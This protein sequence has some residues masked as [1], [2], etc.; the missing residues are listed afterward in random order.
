M[1]HKIFNFIRN[2]IKIPFLIRFIFAFFLIIFSSI[3][4]ILPIFPWS[5]FVWVIIL[6]VGLLLIIHP[7]KI[8]YV[9]KIRKWIIYLMKNFHKET[10]VEHKV[11]DIKAHIKLIL[12][13][14]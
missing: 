7:K 14:K 1:E 13:D 3:P 5:L 9:I 12:K 8:K 2:N 4:I 10:V 11:K 6:V